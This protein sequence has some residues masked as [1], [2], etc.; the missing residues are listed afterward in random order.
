MPRTTD[1]NGK[2]SPHPVSLLCCI[3][4]FHTLVQPISLEIGTYNQTNMKG[5]NLS[6]AIGN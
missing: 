6:F 5:Q 1:T 3:L 2:A 4:K